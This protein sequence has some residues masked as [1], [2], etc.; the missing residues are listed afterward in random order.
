MQK[1][2]RVL[3]LDGGGMRGLYTATVLQGMVDLFRPDLKGKGGDLGQSFDLICGT[4]TG[5]I[6]ATAL[7]NGTALSDVQS[8]YEDH[9]TKIFHSPQPQTSKRFKSLSWLCKHMRK[10]S[11]CASSLKVALEEAFE[12]KTLSELY[13]ERKVA[14]CIPTVNAHTHSPMVM[15]TPHNPLKRMNDNW[16]LV[17]VCM[18]SSAAPVFLPIHEMADPDSDNLSRFFADGGLWA[19]NPV[20]I[21]LTEALEQADEC[22]EIQILSVGTN[23]GSSASPIKKTNRGIAAWK[24]GI[25]PLELSMAAQEKGHDFTAKLLIDSLKK[26]GRNVSLVRLAESPTSEEDMKVIGLD[27]ADK[28]AVNTLKTKAYHDASEHH[29]GVLRSDLVGHEWLQDLFSNITTSK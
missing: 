24:A 6:L 16:K 11:S 26:S 10:A 2:Y 8:L 21:G 14:L 12:K 1:P 25:G 13:S 18:A 22:Q 20:L 19:N 9:G 28:K 15:K 4:S 7:A 29:S 27:K 17:D 23:S 5:S 3:C